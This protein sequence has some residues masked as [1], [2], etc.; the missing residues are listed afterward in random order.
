MADGSE[1]IRLRAEELE[2]L[3]DAY[4]AGDL[5]EAKDLPSLL[6]AIR[7]VDGV[8]LDEAQIYIDRAKTLSK[9]IPTPLPPVLREPS[10]ADLEGDALETWRSQRDARHTQALA[11]REEE[12]K[13]R[14]RAAEDS[15]G[16]SC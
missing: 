13:R 3:I 4:V 8:T 7:K 11:D 10:P 6:V 1:I 15:M 14:K 5:A 9:G 12:D 16:R 2:K